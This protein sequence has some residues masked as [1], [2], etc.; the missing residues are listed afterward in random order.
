M[1]Q[2]HWKNRLLQTLRPI[3]LRIKQLKSWVR[4]QPLT[5]TTG[6][7][8]GTSDQIRMLS[9]GSSNLLQ[10]AFFDAASTRSEVI[11][12]VKPLMAGRLLRQYRDQADLILLPLTPF[13]D[14]AP[15]DALTVPDYLDATIV[16]RQSGEAWEKDIREMLRRRLKKALKGGYRFERSQHP[17]DY[18]WFYR[19]MLKPYVQQRH[20]YAAYVEPEEEFCADTDMAV[21]EFVHLQDQRVGG[22]HMKLSSRNPYA[23]FNKIGLCPAASADVQIMREL[24]C[25]IYQRMVQLARSEGHHGLHLGITPPILNNG[26]T[27]YKSG[28]GAEFVP[29]LTHQ[30]YQLHFTNSR[31]AHIRQHAA[32]LVIL[33]QQRLTGVVWGEAEEAAAKIAEA[34]AWRFTGLNAIHCHSIQTGKRIK[35]SETV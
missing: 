32:P 9:L 27:W 18:V 23:Y 6:L 35:T 24:N 1:Y 31:A 14:A 3:Q 10:Q 29:N 33:E 22:V 8:Q 16:F 13:S 2:H 11:G 25:L 12:Y 34:G 21:L 20:S 5:M 26:I 17:D 4:P 15:P 30:R 7:L 19:H 28:W